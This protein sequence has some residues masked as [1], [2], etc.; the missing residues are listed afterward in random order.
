MRS[1]Q[2]WKVIS[3]LQSMGSIFFDSIVYLD[4]FLIQK[5]KPGFRL[6]SAFTWV[7]RMVLSSLQ[8]AI[9]KV[10]LSHNIFSQDFALL[11][12]IWIV[13]QIADCF[14]LIESFSRSPHPLNIDRREELIKVL[15]FQIYWK[16]LRA[17]SLSKRKL[18]NTKHPTKQ[19]FLSFRHFLNSDTLLSWNKE[20]ESACQYRHANFAKQCQLSKKNS[21]K[22]IIQNYFFLTGKRNWRMKF[23][24]CLTRETVEYL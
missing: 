3:A 12:Q 10:H 18:R 6:E 14:F 15:H 23:L 17:P 11:L 13:S 5:F 22:I 4:F 9:Y 24:P 7:F 19:T 16:C 2:I 8:A 20:K 21:G 1:Y